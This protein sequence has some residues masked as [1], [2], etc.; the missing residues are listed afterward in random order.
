MNIKDV[1]LDEVY[2]GKELGIKNC[3]FKKYQLTECPDC[4]KLH[5]V[6]LYKG[7]RPSVRCRSCASKS[8]KLPLVN[9]A[10]EY[11][12]K[13]FQRPRY[14]KERFC[15]KS[16]STSNIN[17]SLRGELS[18][19]WNGGQFIDNGY[20]YV[21]IPKDNPFISMA[22]KSG[23]VLKHRLVVAMKLGVP[24]LKSEV[25][26]HINKNTLDNRIENLK[27][28]TRHTHQSIHIKESGRKRNNGTISP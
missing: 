26:H 6:R 7:E 19:R 24:L 17:H 22:M 28:L 10:C 18:P 4:N 15:S 9:V 1:T 11:C 2:T 20:T 3:P 8:R 27:L 12:G 25:V 13:I 21:H 5:W 16:C 23:Y 14:R